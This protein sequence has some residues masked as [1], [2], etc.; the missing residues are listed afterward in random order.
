[1]SELR[2]SVEVNAP[3]RAVWD[4]VV[5]WDV[6]SEW[7]LLT[8]V[9]GGHGTGARVEAFTGVGRLGFLDTMEIT[10][11]DPPWRCVVRHTGRVVRGT[12][13][14]EVEPLDGGRSRF[15]WA[16]WV[17]PPFGP[18]GGAGLALVKPFVLLGIRYSLR[19]LA[20]RFPGEST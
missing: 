16:E 5:D 7:M 12:A 15:T 11:W 1:M 10:G 14:F 18:L 6:Q 20:A 4:A 2:A 17:V 19:R 13:V 3:P 8:S 9:R